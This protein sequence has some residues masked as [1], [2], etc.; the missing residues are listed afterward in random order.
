MPL[1][2]CT[3]RRVP[4]RRAARGVPA[5]VAAIT[6]AAGLLAVTWPALAA[7]SPAA[8]RPDLA[9][10]S[11][12]LTT[13]R[14]LI[15]GHYYESVPRSA[16][17]G[18]TIDGALALAAT[19]DQDAALRSIVAFLDGNGK[20]GS[21]RTVNSW[22]GIGSGAASGG[23]IAKEA[24]L[25]EA[26][27]E[28]PRHFGGHDLISALD[29]LVCRR[30]SAS[31]SRQCAAAGN[32]VNAT[33]VFDQALGIIAQIRAGQAARAAAPVSYLES[34]R[35][36]DGSF[37]SLIPAG[38]GPDVDSTAMAV[39]ALALVR[40]QNAATDVRSG[41]AWIAS[42]QKRDGGFPGAGG[43]S[44]NSAALAVQALRMAAGQYRA[45]IA[46]GLAFL[47]REQNADGGFRADA[48]GQPGS[49]VRAS[50]QAIS[51][52]AGISYGTLHRD[53]TSRPGGAGRGGSPASGST[54]TIAAAAAAVAVLALGLIAARRRAGK[55]RAG[56]HVKG[57]R[58]PGRA[59]S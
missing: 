13:P 17:F 51:G 36:P 25:A 28:N 4:A 57:D 9:K 23:A 15:R 39:M 31:T 10:A 3:R 24:L 16:D 11:A 27:G 38:G 14:N 48:T 58:L 44:V 1:G 19:G 12:Y 20:D 43:D 37:P 53:L 6:A 45:Q 18:L 54:A 7:S 40:G 21:G 52:A 59:S 35:H 56:R 50:A 47:A 55:Q 32:Y 33:S 41:L 8:G 34:L 2:T 42:R 30:P 26:V 22:T 49:D 5:L 29:G 46:A